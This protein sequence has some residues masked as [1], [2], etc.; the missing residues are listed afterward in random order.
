MTIFGDECAQTCDRV[1]HDNV[2]H[3]N[4]KNSLCFNQPMDIVYTWVNGSDPIHLKQLAHYTQLYASQQQQQS[5]VSNVNNSSNTR[6]NNGNSTTGSHSSTEEQKEENSVSGSNRFRDNE[7][8]RYS[9]R[10]IEK[11]APWV[12][13]VFI[14]TSGQVPHWLNLDNPKVKVCGKICIWH[15]CVCVCA[16]VNEK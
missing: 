8:L 7:E 11:F 5:P 14:V 4:S 1:F 9:L 16:W 15:I 12:R 6:N 13:Q 10:S 2:G 3:I